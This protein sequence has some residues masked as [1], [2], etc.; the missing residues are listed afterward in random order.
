MKRNYY[1]IWFIG[2]GAW[3]FDAAYSLHHRVVG[4]GLIEAAIS[5]GFLGVG[6]LLKKIG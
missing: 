6:F 4:W 3:F 1:W 2:A 5:A